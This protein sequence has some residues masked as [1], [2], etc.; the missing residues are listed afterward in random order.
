MKN[1]KS[2]KSSRRWHRDAKRVRQVGLW[3]RQ[4]GVFAAEEIYVFYE[5]P[6]AF[7]DLYQSWKSAR[8]DARTLQVCQELVG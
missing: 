5:N 8:R 7:S 2:K 3:A 6:K 1:R 4:T